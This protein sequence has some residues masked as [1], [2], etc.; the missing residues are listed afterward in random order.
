MYYTT[1]VSEDIFFVGASDRRLN[2]FENIFPLPNGIS[3]NSYVL[4][5]EKTAVFDAVDKA[6]APTFLNNVASVLKDRKLDY[7]VITHMEPDHAASLM[8]LLNKYPE[9]TVV[10]NNK[11]FTILDQ[12]F[13]YPEIKRLL[14]TEKDILDLGKHK[15]RFF[16]AP[17]VHWPEVMFAYDDTSK[18]LFS[19]DAFGTFGA[20]SGNVFSDEMNFFEDRLDEARRY[21]TNIVGKYG[22]QATNALKK[23]LAYEIE[24]IC[25]L[26]GPVWR[27][28][29]LINK[30]IEKH[31]L[32]ASYT[33]EDSEVV[34]F[35]GSIY[36]GTEEIATV[37]AT[38][39]AHIGVRNV[40]IYDVSITE[41][42]S[43]VAEAFRAKILIF[44]SASYNAGLF[45]YMET[46]LLDLK[47]HSLQNRFVSLIENGSWALSAAKTMNEILDGMK[48]ITFINDTI[49]IK[50]RLQ[51]EQL[52]EIFNLAD[53]IKENL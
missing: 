38:R 17:M 33:P 51:E 3:Y 8:D 29:D 28:K 21:F 26:H 19:A 42:S 50:S 16:L 43:L 52:N 10:G 18:T 24:Y 53:K 9:A 15:I 31:K 48:N 40:K 25:P 6:V 34:I 11:T 47:A 5:D 22:M 4:L 39:L 44:A 27:D 35:Y 36:G 49:S 1:Q 12:F 30:F 2:L 46:L 14:V 20:L 32:W 45:P 37:L 7:I 13:N 23:V 41:V